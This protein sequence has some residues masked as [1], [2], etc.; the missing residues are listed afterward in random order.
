MCL[1]DKKYLKAEWKKY[2][3]LSFVEVNKNGFVFFDGRGTCV[4]MSTLFSSFFLWDHSITN[5]IF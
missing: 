1:K 5:A 3:N 2:R 4:Q